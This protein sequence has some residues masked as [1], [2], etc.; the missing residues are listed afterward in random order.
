LTAIA[1]SAA[2]APRP[3]DPDDAGR[4][5]EAAGTALTEI[6]RAVGPARWIS[7]LYRRS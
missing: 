4:A 2:Y 3:P 5:T 6:R 7:G 1:T